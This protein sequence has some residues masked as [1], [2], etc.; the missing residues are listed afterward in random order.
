M[1]YVFQGFSNPSDPNLPQPPPY[2]EVAESQPT[3]LNNQ[4]TGSPVSSHSSQSEVTIDS[5][6]HSVSSSSSDGGFRD[7]NAHESDTEG[8]RGRLGRHVSSSDDS[9]EEELPRRG[10]ARTAPSGDRIDVVQDEPIA[11]ISN[12]HVP[13]RNRDKGKEDN[14]TDKNIS[15]EKEELVKDKDTHINNVVDSSDIELQGS[16]KTNNDFKQRRENS[17]NDGKPGDNRPSTGGMEGA[18]QALVAKALHQESRDPPRQEPHTGMVNRLD[19]NRRHETNDRNSERPPLAAHRGISRSD[20][21]LAQ[22]QTSAI[23]G[24]RQGTRRSLAEQTLTEET[25]GPNLVVDVD[26]NEVRMVLDGANESDIYRSN[27]T[28]SRSYHH[29]REPIRSDYRRGRNHSSYP[30]RR[31][32][33]GSQEADTRIHD[34]QGPGVSDAGHQIPGPEIGRVNSVNYIPMFIDGNLEDDIYV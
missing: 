19:N 6:R 15:V 17:Q 7:W 27:G 24:L 26:T 10:Q 9:E 14:K 16:N 33:D 21:N 8:R 28:S 29:S 34:A 13:E 3:G 31:R 30:D 2:S 20:G 11:N 22:N 4:A 25:L 23:R 12:S 5:R 32:E 1:V 18:T